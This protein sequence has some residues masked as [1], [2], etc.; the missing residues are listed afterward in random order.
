[1]KENTITHGWLLR[2]K[3]LIDN[4][5]IIVGR[6]LKKCLKMIF[7]TVGKNGCYFDSNKSDL[8][9]D[10]IETCCKCTKSP[11]M[12]QPMR[13]LLWQKAFIEA[14]YAIK[15]ESGADRF[16][17]VLLLVSRKNGKS[18]MLSALILFE[19]MLGGTG[20]DII[21]ASNTDKQAN[22][23]YNGVDTMR[24]MLDPASLD[25]WR[26][27]SYLRNTALMNTVFK[28][29]STSKQKEGYNADSCWI[30][31][32]HE[33]K[34]NGLT[35][36]LEQSQGVK[37]NPKI[38]MISTN[39]FIDGFLDDEIEKGYKILNNEINEY[40]PEYKLLN[41]FLPWFYTIDEEKDVWNGNRRNK[42]WMK[43]SPSLGYFKTYEYEE[44]QVAT[45]RLSQIDRAF[46][47]SK[48][49]NIKQSAATGWLSREIYDYKTEPFGLADLA[50]CVALGGADIAE[51]T[52]LTNARIIIEKDNK[53]YTYSHYFAP[54]IKKEKTPDTSTGAKYDKWERAGLIT[55]VDEPYLNPAVIA[56]WF[57]S[58][59]E[60][61]GINILSCGYDLK[62]ALSFKERME[63]YG[64]PAEIVYQTPAVLDLPYKM[65]EKDFNIKRI[66]G[67]S[68]MDKWCI[69]N[70]TLEIHDSNGWGQGMLKKVKNQNARRIDGA[71]TLGICYA[72]Y[73]VHRD[74]YSVYNQ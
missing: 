54:R 20:M 28:L 38:V 64:I 11:Y 55:F 41:K 14:I 73:N 66:V 21:C 72:V 44:D 70:A 67:L 65:I 59:R 56:D 62:F 35:K 32:V 49:F 30:D 53:I 29:Y 37:N 13:L 71:V 40:D 48:E 36:P 10:F 61:Y 5:E 74:E 27:V 24:I 7:A 60:E 47:F 39:G 15:L 8:A 69:G 51:T 25:T 3:E 18:E 63:A 68:D 1:M 58:L 52:D 34:D 42:L 33:M 57:L 45:A 31:E 16:Q 9:I 6:D 26:N 22:V 12:G 4:K 50:G 17:R 23:L 2:Y 43:A 46:V 19:M